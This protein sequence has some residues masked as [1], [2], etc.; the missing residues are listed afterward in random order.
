MLPTCAPV[1]VDGLKITAQP[2][3]SCTPEFVDHGVSGRRNPES[4]EPGQRPVTYVQ[5]ALADARLE[6]PSPNMEPGL[7]TEPWE[8]FLAIFEPLPP[9]VMRCLPI[10]GNWGLDIEALEALVMANPDFPVQDLVQMAAIV[11]TIEENRRAAAVA[12][13]EQWIP[14]AADPWAMPYS[15]NAMMMD[16]NLARANFDSGSTTGPEGTTPAR[17]AR[18]Q[19]PVKS[20]GLL[21][22][23]LVS[24][25]GM[26][27]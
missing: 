12:W 18:R 6:A 8:A 24:W 1:S 19:P 3:V 26:S 25:E 13:L 27:Q 2:G 11:R 17:R 9:P 4:P 7:P 15:S 5:V 14:V 20:H 10:L 23:P 22:P 16:G 21:Q